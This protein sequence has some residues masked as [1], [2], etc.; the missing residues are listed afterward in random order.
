MGCSSGANEKIAMSKTAGI[1][2]DNWKIPIFK[3]HLDAAGIKYEEPVPFTEDTSVI[4]A[5]YEWVHKIQPV[6]TAAEAE[7]Q[8]LK[9]QH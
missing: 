6:V 5:A 9:V 1:V 8:R 4:K 7:C 3:K 2:C